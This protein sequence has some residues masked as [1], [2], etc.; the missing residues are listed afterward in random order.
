MM[1]R[2]VSG[3]GARLVVRD[4]FYD[5]LAN[6][7]NNLRDWFKGLS[8][9][10]VFNDGKTSAPPRLRG[11]LLRAISPPSLDPDDKVNA[12]RSVRLVG[13]ALKG[14]PLGHSILAM[15]LRCLRVASGSDRLAPARVGLVRLCVND[16]LTREKKGEQIMSESLDPNLDHPAYI[17]GRL[18]A[19]YE[20]L[21][22]QAQRDVN[23][24]VADKYYGLASTYPQL[25]FPK[26]ENLKTA[27][28]RKLRRD[29]PG[30]AVAISRR[31]HELTDKLVPH[32]AKYPAQL[33]LE[34]QGRFVIGYHHQKAEDQRSI[35]E[36]K[37]RK[38]ERAGNT[39]SGE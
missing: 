31:I 23:V 27:H 19:V 5:S 16:I 3:N 37:E 10:D 21:Q 6:I 11:D 25:A 28:L 8:I 1:M 13:R 2:S 12:Q 14:Q 15:A 33:S 39:K 30:A 29:N 4:W 20:G 24:T 9:A 22:F 26:L 36:A 35:Q 38:A 34:D 32:G 18:L 7:K 17:C